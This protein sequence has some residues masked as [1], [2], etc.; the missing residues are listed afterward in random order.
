M[1]KLGEYGSYG[2]CQYSTHFIFDSRPNRRRPHTQKKGQHIY[3]FSTPSSYFAYSIPN[4]LLPFKPPSVWAEWNCFAFFV[5]YHSAAKSIKEKP[6]FRLHPLNF[7]QFPIGSK[8]LCF[9]CLNRCLSL[10]GAAKWK[11]FISCNETLP[12]R[13]LPQLK[14][15]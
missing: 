14:K 8:H 5:V 2:E 12:W 10:E 6:L 1:W 9:E 7:D 3:F 13:L 15:F 11:I 4:F